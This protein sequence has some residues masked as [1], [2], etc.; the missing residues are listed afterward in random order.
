MRTTATDAKNHLGSL[1]ARVRSGE[2]VLVTSRGE[3]IALITPIEPG[4][5]GVDRDRLDSLIAEGVLIPPRST[6]DL[7]ELFA[8]EVPEL[9][10]GMT[11]VDLIDEERDGR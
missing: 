11:A 10:P 2:T 7:S 3:P 5:V 4:Q 9:P 8:G 1:L 6:L